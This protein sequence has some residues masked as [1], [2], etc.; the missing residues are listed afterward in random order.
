M[1]DGYEHVYAKIFELEESNSMNSNLV[2]RH[3]SSGPRA[4]ES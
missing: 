4:V 1:V 3:A 2:D